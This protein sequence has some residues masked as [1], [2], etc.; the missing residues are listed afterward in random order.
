MTLDVVAET[1]PKKTID[2]PVQGGRF[3]MGSNH[4]YPEEAP[5]RWVDIDGFAIERCT[6][7]NAQ[8]ARFVQ[9]TGYVT[10]SEMDLDRTERPGMPDEYYLA[11][12]LVFS[13]PPKPVPLS[14][15]TLWWTFV[16]E[17]NWR[18]PEGPGSSI[19]GREQHP[20]VHVSYVDACAYAEW[21][22]RAIPT[23]AQ[24]EYVAQ[25]CRINSSFGSEN[26]NIWTG[27]F[28]H[29]HA[30]TMAPPFT[31]A[32]ELATPTKNTVDHMLGNV[33]EWTKDYYVPYAKN[34]TKCC[35]TANQATAPKPRV[36]K[37]GSFLCSENYCRRYR[38]TA[39]LDHDERSAASHI[40]FRCVSVS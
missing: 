16:A 17:A 23:E 26:L 19:S 9:Q 10:T 29:Q 40:G 35:T 6:V 22:G 28:P 24:W 14:D 5:A 7:T 18:Q 20:V 34:D 2:I 15:P 38:P 36:L 4:H 39:R 30:K 11:G 27:S 37:G 12:S 3:L 13:M 8:F 1:F 33:W 32:A 21:A 31:V 25:N